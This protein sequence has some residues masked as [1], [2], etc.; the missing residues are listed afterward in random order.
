MRPR[1]NL[2]LV[3]CISCLTI[4]AGCWDLEEVDQ[5]TFVTAL[6]IDRGPR[7]QVILTAQLPLLKEMMPAGSSGGS[8]GRTNFHTISAESS[9]V[10]LNITLKLEELE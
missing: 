7:G 8:K 9:S 4:L 1:K 6:G 2:P 10:Y 3:A 5:R